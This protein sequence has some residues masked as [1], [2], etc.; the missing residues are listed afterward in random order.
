MVD[1]VQRTQQTVD[2]VVAILEGFGRKDS[3]IKT[4]SISANKQ[5]DYNGNRHVFLG[6]RA[7][8]SIDF[9]PNDLQKFTE[10]RGKLLATKI[11]SI[12]GFSLGIPRQTA[13]FGKPIC[14]LMMMPYNPLKNYPVGQELTW[15]SCCM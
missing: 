14:W 3:D 4:S 13:F 15:A 9:V 1:A 10:L 5:Y 7:E 8:Q 2:G 11:Q 12:S 6:Y